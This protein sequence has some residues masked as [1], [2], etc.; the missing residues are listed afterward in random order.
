MQQPNYLEGISLSRMKEITKSGDRNMQIYLAAK[1]Y[2]RFG[3]YIVPIRPNSK[4]L[5]GAE[6]SGFNYTKASRS[7]AVIDKWFHP[8]DGRFAGWNL[9]IA[10]GREGGVFALDV[11]RHGAE[12]GLANLNAL[13]DEF[14]P[15]PDGPKAKTP[16]DGIH[17]LFRWQENAINSTAK[18]APAID[19]RGGDENSCKGHIVAWPSI[20]NGKMYEWIEGGGIP[21][22]PAWVMEKM[23][24]TWKPKGYGRGNENV[25]LDDLE[26]KIDLDQ[27]KRMLAAINPDDLGYDEWLR[28][29]LSIKSQHIDEKGLEV[30]DEWSKQGKRYKA[31]ECDKRWNGFSLFGT[32]RA[33]TLFYYA[34]Q[35]GWE[36]DKKDLQGS[37]HDEV[38][39][40]INHQFSIVTVGGKIRILREKD[41]IMDPVLGHYD[42]LGK[43]D[44]KTLLQNDMIIGVNIK[45]QPVEMMVSDIWLGHEG[46]REYPNG[47]GLFPD[48]KIPPGYYNTW[49]GWAVAPRKGDCEL[50][51]KHIKEVICRGNEDYYNWTIDWCADFIQ[52]PSCPKGTAIVMRGGE[53]TG[54]GTFASAIGEL[55][56]VHYRHLIDDNHLLN[57]FNAHMIDALFVFADE[58]TWGGNRKT[59]G[60]LNGIVTETHLLGERK[61]V[62]AVPYRNMMRMMIASNSEWIIP[63]GTDSRR[64][65]VLDMLEDKKGDIQYFS[66]IKNELDN[67]GREA[68]LYFLINRKITSNLRIVPVTKALKD[69]RVRSLSSDTV[70]SFWQEIVVREQLDVAN[71]GDFDVNNPAPA[72]PDQVNKGELYDKY[73]EWCNK[74]KVNPEH[75]TVFSK[76]LIGDL[77]VKS[78]RARI[79]DSRPW[80]F[81]LP[82]LADS[83]KIMTDKYNLDF[84]ESDDE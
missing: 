3:I 36:P 19:T 20:I 15:L 72:W 67:G 69:Q 47:I 50:F 65:F 56:G 10:T 62:D 30:W 63:A 35:A 37:K 11:D 57:H 54:K 76:K 80:V 25:G 81:K 2:I 23:G 28:V 58:I 5:P 16:N 53:G 43:D 84:E 14:G 64:W 6:Y 55:A 61:G 45:G 41:Y 48:G 83:K 32:V 34:K 22:I 7:V 78:V 71:E 51:L 73:I 40:R 52:Y 18:I 4:I 27:I 79:G 66:E 31:G 39:E 1:E 33:G 46:R 42:L 77:G 38:V 60:K 29:G 13:T 68:L 17:V 59:A 70:V 9:G 24:I 75:L 12:D 26:R 8:T 74:R 21:D 82:S 44:F 49:N